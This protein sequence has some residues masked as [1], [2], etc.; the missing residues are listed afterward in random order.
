VLI[1]DYR[2]FGRSS[3]VPSEKGLYT[4]IST[5]W[6]FLTVDMKISEKNIIVF[7]HSLGTSISSNLVATLVKKKLPLPKGLI[8]EA[9]FTTMKDLARNIMPSLAFLLMYGFNNIN[10]LKIIKKNVPVCLFHS[11]LDETIPY[12][13][14][15]TIKRVI[16]CDMMDIYGAHCS[17][18]YDDTIEFY[19]KS[20]SE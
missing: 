20:L 11:K 7:G 16:G 4:D 18:Q 17:P 5:I 9:P 15:L 2:G 6:N 13:H 19:L 12:D 10:N 14:S 1:Y 3:G 8:L